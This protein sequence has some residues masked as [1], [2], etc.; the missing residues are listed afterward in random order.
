M[1]HKP[2]QNE[3]R[4]EINFTERVYWDT[5]GDEEKPAS[6]GNGIGQACLQWH[7]LRSSAWSAP[8][9]WGGICVVVGRS[10]KY[11]MK[12][13]DFSFIIRWKRRWRRG[14]KTRR[15]F[16]FFSPPTIF[17]F[18]IRRFFCSFSLIDA[19][20]VCEANN[21]SDSSS[22]KFALD[23]IFEAFFSLK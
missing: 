12:S 4:I 19:R 6:F 21:E 22:P 8:T 16:V 18:K 9:G 10:F 5:K 11:F 15:D 1:T 2:N 23:A 14:V 20:T 3:E 13:L 17:V 7:S